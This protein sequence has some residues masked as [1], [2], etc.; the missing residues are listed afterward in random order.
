MNLEKNWVH[1]QSYQS[2]MA[3]EPCN[4]LMTGSSKPVPTMDVTKADRQASKVTGCA[5]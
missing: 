5:G 3:P 1:I 2:N 4:L